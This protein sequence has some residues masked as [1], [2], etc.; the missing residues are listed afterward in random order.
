MNV[1][2]G[3]KLKL[4]AKLSTAVAS[5]LNKTTSLVTGMKD[6]GP[7]ITFVVFFEMKNGGA[8]VVVDEAIPINELKE[9]R[10]DL[11]ER[12]KLVCKEDGDVLVAVNVKSFGKNAFV[13]WVVSFVF[14]VDLV[15][16][17]VEEE[18]TIVDVDWLDDEFSLNF[19]RNCSTI[20]CI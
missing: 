6:D 14:K 5:S 11:E 16:D 8:K 4:L 3:N 15:V 13:D 17:C 19:F 20:I 2:G 1:I 18:I 12:E 9:S 7:F 10:V